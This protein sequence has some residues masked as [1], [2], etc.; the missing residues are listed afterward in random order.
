MVN[1]EDIAQLNAMEAKENRG[2]NQKS[3]GTKE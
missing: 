2:T 1:P 3:T